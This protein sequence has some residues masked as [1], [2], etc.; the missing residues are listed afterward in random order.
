MLMGVDTRLIASLH[1]S[2]QWYLLGVDYIYVV[3]E[4][5]HEDVGQQVEVPRAS[6]HKIIVAQKII[7]AVFN[8]SAQSLKITSLV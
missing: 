4:L 8:G 1:P 6:D 5:P 3:A 2:T 7:F